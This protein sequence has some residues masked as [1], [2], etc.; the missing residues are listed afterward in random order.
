MLS[1]ALAEKLASRSTAAGLLRA[2]LGEPNVATSSSW[3]KLFGSFPPRGTVAR[4]A[5]R[6][7]AELQKSS[8]FSGY[9]SLA[10]FKMEVRRLTRWYQPGR[11]VSMRRRP[12]ICRHPGQA[13]HVAGRRTTITS[14]VR[15]HYKR[16]VKPLRLEGM[17][18]WREVAL[19]LHE[20]QI[21]LQTG[22]VSVE[23][24]WASLLEM[25]P[26]G[27]RSMAEAWFHMLSM[28]AFLRHNIRHFRCGSLPSWC[29]GDS[30]LAQRLDGLAACLT[31][32]EEGG[33]DHLQPLFEPF[34]D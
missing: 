17:W 26:D 18:K 16:L 4:I 27:A 3:K 14:K 30:L 8:K 10:E 33:G 20:A 31:A 19:A 29:G 32:L 13:P 9:A 34:V 7:G 1:T 23:R 11:R 25:L 28:V 6:C 24:Y 21:P 2:W 15:A 22:T 5:R 12:G